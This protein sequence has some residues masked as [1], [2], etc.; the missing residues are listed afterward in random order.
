MMD[1]LIKLTV[2]IISPCISI[3]N[4]HIIN[5]YNYICQLL[6]TKTGKIKYDLKKD[7]LLE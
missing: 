4:H 5:I 6:L 1:V 3:S 2:I 7:S